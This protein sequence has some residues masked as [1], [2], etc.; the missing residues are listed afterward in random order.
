MFNA[1]HDSTVSGFTEISPVQEAGLEIGDRIVQINGR[2]VN[3]HGDFTLEM[4]RADGSPIELVVERGGQRMQRG[5]EQ[6]GVD[7]VAGDVGVGG[8]FHLGINGLGV[9]VVM[10]DAA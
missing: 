2:N 1:S 9:V 4:M 10:A 8:Q 7:A 6:G 5:V 3:I